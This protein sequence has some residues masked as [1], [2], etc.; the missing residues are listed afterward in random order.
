[1]NG[2]AIDERRADLDW[3]RV[4]AFGLLIYF[5]AAVVFLPSGIPMIQNAQPSPVLQVF[6]AFLHQFRLAL[7]FL[8]SGVGVCFALRNRDRRAFLRDRAARLLIPLAAGIL[9]VVPPMVYL[10]KRFLAT[11]D[12]SLVDFYAG[13][14]TSG[15]YPRGNLSWH[16]YWF[17]AYLYLFCL[18]GWPLFAYW[19]SAAGQAQLARWTEVLVR[20]ASVYLF[21]VP[22]AIVEVA[23]RAVFPGFR[24][25]IHDWA[26]FS[27]WFAIL[28][29]GFVFASSAPLL[30][31]VEQ[32]RALS[33]GLGLCTTGLLFAQFWSPAQSSFTPLRDGEADVAR[34][35]WFCLVRVANVWFWLLACLGFAGR[36]LRHPGRVL[37]Y[38]NE[39]VYPLFCLHLSVIVALAYLVV[40][41]DW[42]I[43]AKYL[44]ITTGTVVLTLVL[45][46]G[47]RRVPLLR[48]LF[49]LKPARRTV[50]APRTGAADGASCSGLADPG[51]RGG[52]VRR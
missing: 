28:L 31:R 35:V 20:G 50:T 5:H 47:I 46:E 8:I 4:I 2:L 36:F 44:C 16:H 34:Y 11:F 7:L 24:D 45:Y 23:L 32:L 10:E 43:A 29:A 49:G 41:L 17:I 27:Q 40:P 14:L 1:M 15:V 18:L 25:L 42:S 37:D 12:A 21:V 48:P 22:L 33:F 30:G 9:L 13:L 26:S 38:L 19:K 51:E 39:A 3:L 52:V 6:V